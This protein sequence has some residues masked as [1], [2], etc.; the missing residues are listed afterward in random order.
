MGQF[1]KEIEQRLKNLAS[2]I[3]HFEGNSELSCEIYYYCQSQHS[4]YDINDIVDMLNKEDQLKERLDAYYENEALCDNGLNFD[5]NGE[6]YLHFNDEKSISHDVVFG[7]NFEPQEEC[8]ND[9]ILTPLEECVDSADSNDIFPR[10]DHEDVPLVN[11][12]AV[13]F[14]ENIFEMLKIEKPLLSP[15]S[16]ENTVH[17]VEPLFI[18]SPHPKLVD[19]SLRKPP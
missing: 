18:D 17:G 19:Y 9:E 16:F 4:T 12:Q 14:Q 5:E 13:I 7:L 6:S 1:G 15:K 10:K 11:F 8:I 2:Q 3:C